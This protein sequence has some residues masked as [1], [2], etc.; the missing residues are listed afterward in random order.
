MEL[1]SLNIGVPRIF[2]D[3]DAIDPMRKEWTSGIL[4][5][6]V[7]GPLFLGRFKLQ[8]DKQA[9]QENHGGPDKAVN[10][11]PAEHYSH[12]QAVLGIENM[13]YGAF[14]E[15]FTTGGLLEE[16]VCIGD[17]FQ[18]G[19]ALVQISQPRQPCWK[20]ARRWQVKDLVV[21]V[22]ETGFTGWYFRVLRE[23][24]VE[25]GMSFSRVEQ[26]EAK[27]SVAEANAVMFHRKNDLGAASALASCPALSE[28]WRQSLLQRVERV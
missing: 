19:D 8:G 20:L 4:K 22:Q 21:Q 2:G 18:I 25:A 24:V 16:S 7:A 11:Y 6:S 5:E 3:A 28:S 17:V 10:A 27:W 14:G 15:N 12:W 26:A 23:G 9:D 13:P 1:L